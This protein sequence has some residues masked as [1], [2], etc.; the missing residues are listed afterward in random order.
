MTQRGVQMPNRENPVRG[1]RKYKEPAP[2][3]VFLTLS[4]IEEQLIALKNDLLT[5][6]SWSQ[7]LFTQDCDAKNCCG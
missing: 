5:S 2:E 6:R 3:I 4:Q 7:S 1:V